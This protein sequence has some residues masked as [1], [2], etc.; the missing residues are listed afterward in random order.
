MTPFAFTIAELECAARQRLPFVA[1]VADD[2]Q[3]G[4]S[5]T[6]HRKRY[7][8]DLYSMLGPTRLDNVAEGFGCHG[9]RVDTLG[10]L[11]SEL[12]E[13]LRRAD[14]PTVIHVP[15]VPGWPGE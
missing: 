13:A 8:D 12:D 7:G 11:D 4:N 3:W 9:V 5:V 6:G 10:Q 2:E 14:V 1:V 15:I